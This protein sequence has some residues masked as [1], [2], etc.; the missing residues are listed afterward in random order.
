V[1]AP[2][3]RPRGRGHGD[4]LARGLTQTEAHLRDLVPAGPAA[5]FIVDALG[6]CTHCQGDALGHLGLD[7]RARGSVLVDRTRSITVALSVRR[8]MAGEAVAEHIEI[9]DQILALHVTPLVGGGVLGSA[10]DVTPLREAGRRLA[11]DAFVDPLT[12]LATRGH[13]LAELEVARAMAEVEGWKVAVV[14]IDFDRFGV[15]NDLLGHQEGDRVLATAAARLK[16]VCREGDLIGR[17]GGDEYAVLLPDVTSGADALVVA[18]RFAAELVR[19]FVVDAR[20][21]YLTASAGVGFG[22]ASAELAESLLLDAA[23]AVRWARERGRGRCELFDQTLRAR[24]LHRM[25]TRSALHRALERDEL[26]LHYQPLIDLATGA[27]EG[28]EALIRWQ[29]PTLGLMSP[30][31]FVPEAEETGLIVP[32]GRWVAEEACR[33]LAAWRD[34]VD[35][36]LPPGFGMSVNLSAAQLH[37]PALPEQI[38]AALDDA[39]VEPAHLTLEITES[40]LLDDTEAVIATLNRLRDQGTDLAVDD[41]GTGFSSLSYLKRLPVSALKVDRTFVAGMHTERA[42]RAI[43]NAVVGLAHDL[44]LRAIAEGVETDTDLAAVR[45]LG[46]DGAQGYLFSPPLPPDTLAARLRER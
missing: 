45:H 29:H 12:G 23:S 19:P 5:L 9:G 22:L 4:A 40:M 1:E 27:W 7:G 32:I 8:A 26:R 13:F 36:G 42:D 41:F 34:D 18:R 35:Q 3:S 25:E 2:R 46:C 10:V 6:V 38:R 28:V 11:R 24:S 15:V 31:H 20:E 43:A 37:D 16:A 44:D 17:V 30:D 21:V 39:G 14:L 33:Q